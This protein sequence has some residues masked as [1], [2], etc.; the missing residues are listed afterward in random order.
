MKAGGIEQ[1]LQ[2]ELDLNR[3]IELYNQR[4]VHFAQVDRAQ[5]ERDMR[6][7][8]SKCREKLIQP[9]VLWLGYQRPFQQDE[10]EKLFLNE[11]E[12]RDLLN[13]LE[14]AETKLI[15]AYGEKLDV[16]LADFNDVEE[17]K[18]LYR[19]ELGEKLKQKRARQKQIREERE[20]MR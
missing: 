15:E 9:S 16:V 2:E 17:L 20:R 5:W 6:Q 4:E 8:E 18:K 3:R 13:D 12:R 10:M 19:D 1:I 14:A 7:F 11:K